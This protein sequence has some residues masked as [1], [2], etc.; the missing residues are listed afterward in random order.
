VVPRQP[1]KRAT[2]SNAEV[3]RDARR[4]AVV[5][6]KLCSQHETQDWKCLAPIRILGP[7]KP[8]GS[9]DGAII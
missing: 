7:T 5:P 9:S 8:D 4:V 2:R 3:Q 6:K 1:V